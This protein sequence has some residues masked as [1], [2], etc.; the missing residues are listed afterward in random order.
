VDLLFL[1]ANG[2]SA[3][4]REHQQFLKQ[5]CGSFRQNRERQP[6]ISAASMVMTDLN[7]DGSKVTNYCGANPVL[8]PGWYLSE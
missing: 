2:S 1:R 6:P 4:N 7:N 3:Q 8:A 5:C